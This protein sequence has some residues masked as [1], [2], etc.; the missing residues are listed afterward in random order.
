MLQIYRRT[1][2]TYII[3]SNFIKTTLRH[4]C[5]PL[6]LL[7]IFRPPSY[8]NAYRGCFC[9]KVSKNISYYKAKC[10]ID[11]I[12]FARLVP[13]YASDVCF[14][15]FPT[16]SLNCLGKEKQG[17]SKGSKFLFLVKQIYFVF[18]EKLLCLCLQF[19]FHNFFNCFDSDI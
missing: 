5:S 1:P 7:N 18:V 4:G 2:F 19:F 6:Y 13:K 8:K 10:V 15:T 3:S 9:L 14:A 17:V 11:S 12:G 16:N